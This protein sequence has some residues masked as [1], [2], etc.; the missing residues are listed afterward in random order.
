MKKI[1][2]ITLLFSKF[3]VAQSQFNTE[4]LTTTRADLELNEFKQD[5]T[6]NAI[7]LY[8]YGDAEIHKKTFNLVLDYKKKVK[9]L[10]RNGFDQAN[11]EVYLYNSD[12]KSEKITNL[13]ATTTNIEDG[14]VTRINL[15]PSQV[16]EEKVNDNYTIFKFVLPN[17]KE[18]SV[19]TYSYTFESPFLFNFNSWKFQED[20][21]KLYSEYNTSI[22][23]NYDYNIKL[24]GE[25]KLSVNQSDIKKY[26][27][28]LD[29]GAS[30]DCTIGKYVMKDIPAFIEEDYTTASK[31]Y[32]SRMEYELKVIKG[33]DG[34]VQN[35]TK[36]WETADDELKQNEDFGKQLKKESLVKKLIDPTLLDQKSDLDK[37]KYI[38]NY[39]KNNYTW[40]GYY[41]IFKD[42]SIKDIIEE[43]TGNVAEINLL[44]YNLLKRHDIIT[45][46][47]LISTRENGFITTLYPVISE[48]NYVILRAEINGKSYFLDAT[49]PLLVFGQ[50][51]FKCLNEYGREMDFDNDSRWIDLNTNIN[52]TTQHKVNIKIND[53]NTFSGTLT[54]TKLGY[55][56]L[57][58]RQ[59][60]KKNNLNN[61]KYFREKYPDLTFENSQVDTNKNDKA[62]YTETI[63]I[64]GPLTVIGDKIYLDPFIFKFFTK[65]PL[66]LNTRTYPIDF[67]YKNNLIYYIQIDTNDKYKIVDK[68]LDKTIELSNNSGLLNFLTQ[69]KNGNIDLSFRINFYNTIYPTNYYTEL[70][71]FFSNIVNIQNNS[72]IVLEKNI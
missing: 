60:Y 34:S 44:L 42:V 68:P 11:I 2:L 7:V 37:A 9:I 19:I 20:I 24:V 18:G 47:V 8:E 49:D 52:S 10:N 17:I 36:T 51:P 21:P 15:D 72:V 14:K 25:L 6:A 4:N 63:S 43:K 61:L 64:S 3:L 29:N 35:I 12:R 66:Q 45:Y 26:C 62:I 57:D 65:N 71:S 56:A 58:A 33:F 50:I 69:P 55:D 16:F 31:N 41:R 70:K 38:F 46:P 13:V 59:L 30:A 22:P 1:F 32:I 53:D 23:G 39:V 27:I 54:T 67:G 5:T 48:F 40:N 28:Q